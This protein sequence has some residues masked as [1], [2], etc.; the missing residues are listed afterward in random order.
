MGRNKK[1]TLSQN[2]R[3]LGLVSRLRGPT[4]GIEKSLTESREDKTP[5][6]AVR[7]T[8]STVIS[9]A[10]VERD[11]DGKIVR[12]LS[13]KR[14]ENPLG[15]LLNEVEDQEE[16]GGI[17]DEG[18]KTEVVKELEELA[19]RP[20]VKRPRYVSERE[21]EWLERLVGRHGDDYGAMA[22]DRK[23]NPMQQTAADI[24]RRVRKMRGE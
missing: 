15:D 12:V 22:R 10:K 6:L 3:R 14:K 13:G 11:A 4:G 16:W 1:E 24:A 7:N 9:E 5:F 17:D 20:E 19:A 23:L 21:G 8:E 2:Y 18:K